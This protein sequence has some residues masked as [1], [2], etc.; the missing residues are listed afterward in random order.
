MNLL[1]GLAGLRSLPAGA[2][3]SIGNFDGVHRGHQRLLE[4]ARALKLSTPARTLAVA[5]FEPHPLTVL[6]PGHAPPRLTCLN[7]KR[8]LLAD[9]GVDVLIEL[10]PAQEVLNLSAEQFWA[11]L[12][13]EARIAHL[14]EGHSFNFGKGRGG[15]IEKLQTWTRE[16]DVRLHLVDSVKV[17]LLDMQIVPVS[18]TTIRWLL[19]QGRVRDA[20]ICLGRAYTLD[21][22]VVAG[23]ARG[24]E[25][26]CPTANLQCSDQIIP[27][28]G[29]YAGR[30]RVDDYFW[31]AA[32]SIGTNP[33]FGQNP[34]TIEAHLIGFCGDLYGQSL[35][36]DLLDWQREQRTFAGVE[37][38]K[39]WIARDIQ[40][41]L[42]RSGMDP[43]QPVAKLSG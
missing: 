7:L 32:V 35:Q 1:K 8:K 18:S 31:P 6:R 3:L 15:T 27:S 16:G 39:D 10:P 30:C 5:T 26:G 34:R 4:I 43:S 21:G 25:L 41:T 17:P 13:D 33:T 19:E 37:A 23:A 20:A 12:R 22:T 28:D 24:R 36:L 40:Q 11:I 42:A 2:V 38:L 14:V 9:A 29:V